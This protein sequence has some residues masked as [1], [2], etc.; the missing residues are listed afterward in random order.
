MQRAMENNMG[1]GKADA[2]GIEAYRGVGMKP[3]MSL[4]KAFIK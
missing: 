4:V 3:T 2:K 1:G